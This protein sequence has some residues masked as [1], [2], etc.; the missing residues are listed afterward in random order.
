MK[1]D[2]TF[3]R[4]DLVPPVVDPDHIQLARFQEHSYVAGPGR[5]C[6]VWVSG[7]RRRCPG[8]FQSQFFEFNAGQRVSVDLV[9]DQILAVSGIDGVT[10]S[11]GEPFEQ[12]APLAKLCQRIKDES[13]LTVLAYTGYR[14]ES[15]LQSRDQYAALL[16]QLDILIDGEYRQELGGPYLWR[17]S[18]NQRIHDLRNKADSRAIENEC[19][20]HSEMIQVAV[21]GERIVLTGFPGPDVDKRFRQALESRGIALSRPHDKRQVNE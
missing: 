3:L 7:C 13:E 16:E 4:N 14:L 12:N 21:S 9:A 8:C 6:V 18:S 11:G 5:R 17:G 15:L 1:V 20:L 2:A 19:V 10:L